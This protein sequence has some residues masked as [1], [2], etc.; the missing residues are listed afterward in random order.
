MRFIL[1]TIASLLSVAIAALLMY[2]VFIQPVSVLAYEQ[3]TE[4]DFYGIQ[5]FADSQICNTVHERY[6]QYY[7]QPAISCQK[8]VDCN[9]F[10][11]KMTCDS[12]ISVN[13]EG[14]EKLNILYQ[15]VSFNCFMP[16]QRKPRKIRCPETPFYNYQSVCLNQQCVA[17]PEINMGKM[18]SLIH[19]MNQKLE[20][21]TNN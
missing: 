12:P 17:I 16:T 5:Q 20:P 18:K 3:K 6:K 14:L 15:S 9:V 11:S 8:D 19:R 1:F 21:H 2:H 10:A 13:T 7:E 4:I